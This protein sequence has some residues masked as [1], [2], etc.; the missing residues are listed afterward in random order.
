MFGQSEMLD[1]RPQITN[2]LRS[3]DETLLSVGRL[4]LTRRELSSLVDGH[5]LSRTVIDAYFAVLQ[6]LGR[7]MSQA[8]DSAPRVLLAK[9]DFVHSILI[10]LEYIPCQTYA[11]HFE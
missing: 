7:R 1:L 8:K 5:E 3:A 9:T 10:K 11:F 4:N 2:S 6:Q